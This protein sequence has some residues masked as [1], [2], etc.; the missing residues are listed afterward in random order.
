[1]KPSPPKKDKNLSDRQPPVIFKTSDFFG[2]TSSE[3]QST[4]DT[5]DSDKDTLTLSSIDQTQDT[6]VQSTDS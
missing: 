5:Q 4:D 2:L 6:M 1:M 3:A